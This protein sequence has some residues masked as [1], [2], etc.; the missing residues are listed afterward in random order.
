MKTPRIVISIAMGVALATAHAA[1]GGRAEGLKLEFKMPGHVVRIV[2][3]GPNEL[4]SIG[5]YSIIVYSPDGSEF[6]AGVVRDRDGEV[7][8]VWVTAGDRGRGLHIWIWTTAAGTG[9]HG[10]IALLQFHGETFREIT[11]PEPNPA[12]LQ[13]HMGHDTFDVVDGTVHWQFL[14]YGPNDSNTRPTGGT[15]RLTL[16][17][18]RKAWETI[19]RQENS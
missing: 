8:K 4:A 5:S 10:Q 14:V 17:L 6:F 2:P 15:R 7:S 16:G 18:D 3:T 19:Q 13:G 12:L 1:V 9:A 11:I